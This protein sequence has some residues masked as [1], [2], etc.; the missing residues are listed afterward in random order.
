MELEQII[1]AIEYLTAINSGLLKEIELLKAK[2]RA[3]ETQAVLVYERK[4]VVEE[5]KLAMFRL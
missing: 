4:V 2:V 1:K 3:V 5:R